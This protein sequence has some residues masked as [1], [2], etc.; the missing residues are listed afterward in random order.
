[1]DHSEFASKLR[2]WEVKANQLVLLTLMNGDVI[3]TCR[4]RPHLVARETPDKGY[5]PNGGVRAFE[6]EDLPF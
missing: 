2:T 4:G 3:I 5:P 1:M 6:D